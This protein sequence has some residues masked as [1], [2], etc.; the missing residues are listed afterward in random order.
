VFQKIGEGD[1][2]DLL[3]QIPTAFHSVTAILVSQLDRYYLA[4]N[5]HGNTEAVVQVYQVVP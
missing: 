1:R 4:V 5:H 2:Y 3:G